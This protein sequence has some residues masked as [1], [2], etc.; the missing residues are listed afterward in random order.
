MLYLISMGL[1]DERDMSLR[2]LETAKECDK[3][4]VE[5]Y[6]N[7]TATS[8]KKLGEL[9]NKDVIELDRK[10][11]EDGANKLICEAKESD[12]GI[13]IP[14]D[15]LSATTHLMLLSEAK[16]AG[17]KTMVIH[18]S[19]VFTAAAQTGLQLYKFGRTVSLTDPVQK[20]VKEHI[21]SNLQAGLHTLVLLDIGMD[22]PKAASILGQ[23]L[24]DNNIH[25]IVCAA[26]LGDPKRILKYQSPTE[27]AGSTDLRGKTPAI[28][29]IP[30]R[31]HFTEEEF[32][33]TLA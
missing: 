26:Q 29:A 6:T 11:M 15:A 33:E 23:F 19:S 21:E 13:I 10:G 18:G 1:R 7:V 22:V 24:N 8:A 16:K 30:G 12:I 4:Y 25:K 2:A 17:I 27:L 31:L 28:L 32:L 5:F 3:L 14:G 9:I 20:S